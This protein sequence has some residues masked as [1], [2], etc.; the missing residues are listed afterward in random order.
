MT[1]KLYSNLT[2]ISISILI[3]LKQCIL[4]VVHMTIAVNIFY[5]SILSKQFLA[6]PS[7]AVAWRVNLIDRKAK[8]VTY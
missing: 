1:L 7:A 3:S 4:K 6:Q 8:E 2:K 5:S